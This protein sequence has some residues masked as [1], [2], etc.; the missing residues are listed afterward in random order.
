[1][2]VYVTGDRQDDV[3]RAARMIR[4]LLRPDDAKNEE[5]KQEQLKQLALLNGA[6]FCVCWGGL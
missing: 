5:H 3:D 6:D 4:E 1:M 2:H